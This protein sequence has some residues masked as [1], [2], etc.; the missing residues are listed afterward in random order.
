MRASVDLPQPDSPTTA[1]VRPASMA[2][3]TPPTACRRAGSRIS[4]R[5]MEYTCRR[6]RAS[7]TGAALGRGGR[8]GHRAHDD[9][10]WRCAPSLERAIRALGRPGGAH[11]AGLASWRSRARAASRSGSPSGKWQRTT[12]PAHGRSSGRWRHRWPGVV[13]A[14]GSEEAAAGP[15]VEAGHHARNGREA[16]LAGAALGHRRR[17]APPCRGAAARRT[18]R[19]RRAP[20]PPG[21]RTSRRRGGPFRTTT[22]MLCVTSTSAMPRSRCSPRSRSRI[23]AWIVTSSAVVGSSAISSRGL[24]AIAIAIITR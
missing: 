20:R 12:P 23:C 2:N 14:A 8:S 24:Q 22:P 11:A 5:E 10:L 15:I 3:D 6:S 4:P 9:T 1:S 21:P 13:A 18:A 7:A 17:A 16:P 19:R